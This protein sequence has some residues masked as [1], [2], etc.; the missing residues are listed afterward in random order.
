MNRR[1]EIA[2]KTLNPVW[3]QDFRLELW[4]DESAQEEPLEL[5][6]VVVIA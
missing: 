6:Y 4:D 5:K 2:H 1:T 3:N